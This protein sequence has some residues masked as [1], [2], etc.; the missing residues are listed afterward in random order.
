MT[1]GVPGNVPYIITVG[2]MSDNYTPDDGT[3][4]SSD[5][6]FGAGPTVEGFVKPDVLAPGGHIQGVMPPYA[7][8]ALDHPEFQDRTVLFHHVGHVTGHGRY[9]RRRRPDA[10]GQPHV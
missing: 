3:D 6:I 1:I 7:Q 5:F 10:T 4:D 9:Q 8:I 2:A